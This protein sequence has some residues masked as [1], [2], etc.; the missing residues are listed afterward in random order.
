LLAP[1]VKPG[2]LD[3]TEVTVPLGVSVLMPLASQALPV[4]VNTSLL[5]LAVGNATSMLLVPLPVMVMPRV[6]VM[7]TFFI[8]LLVNS[9]VTFSVMYFR[10]SSPSSVGKFSVM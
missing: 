10:I 7:V 9:W 1:K 8:T 4:Q 6:P 2:T 5:A 3:V